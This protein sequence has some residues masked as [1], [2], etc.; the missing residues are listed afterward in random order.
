MVVTVSAVIFLWGLQFKF[1]LATLQ[2]EIKKP[3]DNEL[4]Q[5]LEQIKKDTTEA[6]EKA[7]N[8]RTIFEKQQYASSTIEDTATASST[9][10]N[11][12]ILKMKDKIEQ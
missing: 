2:Q 5:Q 8:A 12:I 7:K 9:I 10:S 11:D 1:T 4:K 6:Y 3:M